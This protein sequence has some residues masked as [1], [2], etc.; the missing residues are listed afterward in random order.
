[1]CDCTHH[2]FKVFY[3]CQVIR[4]HP[5]VFEIYQRKLL[6]PGKISKK[7]I[8]KLNKKVSTVLNEYFENSK[9]CVPNK[10]D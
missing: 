10:R 6:E 9:D 1:M 2:I 5:S 4:N 8:D 7:Y 3:L